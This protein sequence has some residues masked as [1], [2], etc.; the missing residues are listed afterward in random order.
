MHTLSCGYNG[1]CLDL[2]LVWMH[3]VPMGGCG[4]SDAVGSGGQNLNQNPLKV[5]T[6]EPISISM[7]ISISIYLHIYISIYLYIYI[8]IYIHTYIIY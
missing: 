1:T 7:T 2:S 4:A 5:C 8:Y 6:R 3:P